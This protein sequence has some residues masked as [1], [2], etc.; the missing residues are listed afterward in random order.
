M[1]RFLICKKLIAIV[2]GAL[3]LLIW[4]VPLWLAQERKPLLKRERQ[5]CPCCGQVVRE[6]LFRK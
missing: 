1:F 3:F 2:A 6:G 4:G 5:V